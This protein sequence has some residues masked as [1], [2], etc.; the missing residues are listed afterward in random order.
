M[1][2]PELLSPAG[3][4]P[5]L[6]AAVE[7]GADAVYLGLKEFS[8]RANAKNFNVSDLKKIADFCHKNKVKVYVTLNTI[9]FEEELKKIGNILDKIR[10]SKADAVIAWDFS[11][12][13]KALER[14]IPIHISTQMSVSN[15]ESAKFF[16][17][18]GAKSINLARECSLKQ[19]KEIKKKTK[20]EIETFMHG[21][22]CVS[23]SGRCF[24]SQFLFK[25]SANR[26][27]CLQP[28]RRSYL[29]KDIETGDELKLNNNYVMSPKDLCAL[30]ILDKLVKA[31]ID[32]LKIEGRNRAPEYVKT[33]TEVYREALDAIQ[34]KK[35]NKQL[36]DK[37]MKKLETVYNRKFSAGFFLGTPTND[38]WTDIYGSNAT[39]KK[40][41]VGLVRN[42]YKK[43]GAAAIFLQ[44]GQIKKGDRIMIIGNTTGVF[45][46]VIETIHKNQKEI[47]VAKKG[48]L[49]GIKISK[50]ARK[51]DKVFVIKK[52]SL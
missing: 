3:D 35:F 33:V 6:R 16:E 48:E 8:M 29:V 21:A 9:I 7:A 22:M 49:V 50:L 1:K 15:S 42:Y 45:E 2:F 28:C 34:N 39:E 43:Q 25:K 26:G 32:R 51:N 41:F 10:Q 37:L 52:T 40:V 17:K 19:I 12:I 5:S 31:G 27:E 13:K 24:T 4:W 14:K 20:L 18:L 23:V 44:S 38:G 36:V 30:P 11:V 47:E 46:Q